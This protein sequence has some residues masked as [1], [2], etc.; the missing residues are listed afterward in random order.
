MENE[1]NVFHFLSSYKLELLEQEYYI[2]S[3]GYEGCSLKEEEKRKIQRFDPFDE[4]DTIGFFIS[5][6]RKIG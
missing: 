3:N 5:K 6:F 1:E 2:G 4:N